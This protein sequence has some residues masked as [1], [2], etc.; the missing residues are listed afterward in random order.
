[1][2]GLRLRTTRE[3][4]PLRRVTSKS[5]T[6][7]RGTNKLRIVAK[8]PRIETWVNGQAVEDLVNDD[9][10]RTHS[11]GFIGLQIH[12]LTER[13]INLP[14]YAGSGVTVNEPLIS[15][16]RNVRIRTIPKRQ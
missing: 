10:Y 3:R 16:W 6:S 8:G 4:L 9:V 5:Q 1:M 13:E 11:T 14:L 15:K 7:T 2:L 12:G